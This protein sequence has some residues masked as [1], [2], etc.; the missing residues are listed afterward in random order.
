MDESQIEIE[1]EIESME[2][3]VKGFIL[4]L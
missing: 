1:I 3:G 4:A 2:E